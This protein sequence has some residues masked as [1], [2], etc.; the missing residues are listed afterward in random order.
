MSR[1]GSVAALVTAAVLSARALP[2]QSTTPWSAIHTTNDE[3]DGKQQYVSAPSQEKNATLHAFCENGFILI[4]LTI[5]QVFDWHSYD[6]R[7]RARIQIRGMDIEDGYVFADVSR[8]FKS[9]EI[10][11]STFQAGLVTV[12]TLALRWQTAAPVGK[13]TAHWSFPNHTTL[14]SLVQSCHHEP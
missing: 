5:T 1:N 6:N 10:D 8:D 3:F 9:A 12:K 4:Q 13:Q 2:G 11:D 7:T 14:N